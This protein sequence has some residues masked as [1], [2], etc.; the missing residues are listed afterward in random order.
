MGLK[1]PT[2]AQLELFESC[3]R[4]DT[5]RV[6][7]WLSSKKNKRPRTPLNFLRPS[8]PGSSWICSIRDPSSAYTPLHLSA[9]HG[10]SEICR[11]L[12]DADPHVTTAKDRRGCIPLHLAAWSGH[13]NI[14]KL[15]TDFEPESVDVINNVGESSLHL[16]AQ[17]GYVKVVGILLDKHSDARLRNV[18]FET[19][20]D[21]AAKYGH[22][23][24]V[25]I[26]VSYCPE[27]ALQ[28][29]AECSSPPIIGG[30]NMVVYPMHLAARNSHILCMQLLRY[31]GF[32]I[33]F[34]TDEGSALHAAAL[35]GQVEAVRFLLREGINALIRD[36]KGRTV[37][38]ALE[39]HE[40][41]R[42]NDLTQVMSV[43]EEWRECRIIIKEYL[44]SE[45]GGR[46]TLSSSSDSGFDR[47]EHGDR[48]HTIDGTDEG[49]WLPI[50]ST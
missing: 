30:K 28:S 27:L 9:L 20:L 37:L 19:A 36:I 12:L 5:E 43:R 21:I 29:A 13:T 17:C 18:R 31:A 38:E 46:G 14:A 47:R 40:S 34:V 23:P 35:H 22:A 2:A 50:P 1:E 15:L 8:T 39:E 45:S 11:L 49:V 24:V 26:L 25:K 44:C 6:R 7:Q 41:D 10:H 4:G 3:K 48:R 32:D 42:A 33:D 16:A